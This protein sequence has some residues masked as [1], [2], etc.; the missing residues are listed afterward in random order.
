VRA[1]WDPVDSRNVP[2][3][4]TV[5][6][7]KSSWNSRSARSADP[8]GISD[9]HDGYQNGSK[10]DKPRRQRPGQ[11]SHPI[12]F[13]IRGRAL[14]D[15]AGACADRGKPAPRRLQ[16][17]GIKERIAHGTF[18]FAEE[19]P[20]YR[21]RKHIGSVTAAA[22]AMTCSTSSRSVESRVAKH[23]S[24]SRPPMATA[25]SGT[26]GDRRWYAT[27]SEVRYS[28]YEDRRCTRRI[29]EDPHNVISALRCAFDYGIAT[30]SEKQIRRLA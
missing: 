18:S 22:H 3:P 25:R 20:D 16:L 8:D 11:E 5:P 28:S 29:E 23:D 19:F 2:A 14:F 17:Q 26:S 15:N 9:R 21:F 13:R 10:V 7:P 1:T 27:V 24:H 6:R 30:T 12:R 4:L